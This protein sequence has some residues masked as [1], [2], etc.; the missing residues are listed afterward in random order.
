MHLVSDLAQDPGC[1][2]HPNARHARCDCKWGKF[3]VK[4]ALRLTP[5]RFSSVT[6]WP[7]DHSR[8]GG[9][10]TGGVTI[11]IPTSSRAHPNGSFS[12]RGISHLFG[13]VVATKVAMFI[14]VKNLLRPLVRRNRWIEAG[15]R[16][17]PDQWGFPNVDKGSWLVKAGNS[18]V[19]TC[20]HV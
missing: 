17:D 14:R 2:S 4:L 10:L 11:Q 16:R 5:P 3:K 19:T 12:C 9:S 6:F 20:L 15:K 8:L 13:T 18:L 1:R 7:R